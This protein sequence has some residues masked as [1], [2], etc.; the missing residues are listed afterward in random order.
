MMQYLPAVLKA[1]LL[2]WMHVLYCLLRMPIM[3]LRLLRPSHHR[4]GVVHARSA[5]ITPSAVALSTLMLV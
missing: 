2:P 5:V 3:F 1:W 4:S